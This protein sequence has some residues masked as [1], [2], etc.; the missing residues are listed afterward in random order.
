MA[1]KPARSGH[2]AIA[3][4]TAKAKP[5]ARAS[6]A[7]S[8]A[9]PASTATTPRSTRSNPNRRGRV[10][11][12]AVA[13]APTPAPTK[14]ATRGA[15]PSGK[16]EKE[17]AAKQP[18][19]ARQPKVASNSAASA[20]TTPTPK[21]PRS[22]KRKH[23]EGDSGA[24]DSKRAAGPAAARDASAKRSSSPRGPKRT[25]AL[26]AAAQ[27]LAGLSKAEAQTGVTAPDLIDRMSTSG[28]WTSPGGKTPAATLYA[29][30]IREITRKG[31]A[32]RFKRV[33]PGRF[34]PSAAATKPASRTSR[35]VKTSA[36]V[37][38]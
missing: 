18:A 36:E 22:T 14:A 6:T 7:A 24:T 9:A 38:A 37:A 30:M 3:S 26:D 13:N 31:D 23:A 2:A 8:A 11:V 19:S 35:T 32:S 21:T 12:D 27:V 33:A 29:A 1:R 5:D 34:A 15:K 28:L 25:S 16:V 17:S 4:G 20:T 10:D